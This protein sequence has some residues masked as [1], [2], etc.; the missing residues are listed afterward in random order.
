[1]K[2]G[3]EI[4]NLGDVCEILNGGTPDTSIPKFWDGENLWITP[5]DMGKLRSIFVD[6][7]LRKITD[8][9]LKNSSAKILPPNSIILSSRAPIGHLAINIRPM[10]T[11]QGCKGLVPNKKIGNLFLYYFL[12]KSVDL[13]NSL[14]TGTT[15]KELSGSKLASVEIP[16]PPLSEQQ[17]IVSI[18]DDAFESIEHAK[19]NA[20]QN[21][22]NAK[23][24]FE[25][26]LQNI[27][28]NKAK[29][30]EEKNLGEV[31][32]FRNGAAHEQHID[33]NGKYI[34]I[35]SK[36]ISSD[37]KKGKRT[38]SLLSPLYIGD[39]A[40]VMSD[41]P[42][43]KALAKCFLIE[44]ND[45]YTLNQRIG[46]IRSKFFN[47]EFFLYQFNRHKYLLSF[48]NGENQT[49]LRKN[50]ILNCPLYLPKIEEQKSIVNKLDDLSIETKRL[51][52]IYEQKLNDLE[53]LKKSILQ[54]AFNGE[55]KTSKIS[56]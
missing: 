20:E 2:K 13:L 43:G 32:E 54:K 5:K 41:V 55:L 46:A 50:D 19:S 40:F 44:K 23:E 39:I 42:N 34:L 48:N 6:D 26:Y 31:C 7:T 12:Y 15:F 8:D 3:W 29:D 38:N 28:K 49:N 1:M 51:E 16:L 9:G 37:G 33:I 36:F 17:E 4:K 18:L 30:W 25:S 52:S 22:K 10:S 21:L 11:N 35:N 24:L 53:E 56:I 47:N 45:T 14:G 27:F